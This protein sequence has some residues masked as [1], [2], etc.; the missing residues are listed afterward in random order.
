M[1]YQYSIRVIFWVLQ[2]LGARLAPT[3]VAGGTYLHQA[4]NKVGGDASFSRHQTLSEFRETAISHNSQRCMDFLEDTCWECYYTP[5]KLSMRSWVGW[6]QV[7]V[8]GQQSFPISPWCLQFL[9][10]CTGAQ[11]HSHPL[12]ASWSLCLLW[13]WHWGAQ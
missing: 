1:Y 5:S 13:M 8:T 2:Q 9:Y 7:G 12:P 6:G 11:L 3:T 4:P 10:P